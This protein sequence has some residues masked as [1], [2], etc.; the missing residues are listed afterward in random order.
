MNK[1]NISTVY[2]NY[3][4]NNKIYQCC[5]SF[6]IKTVSMW[7]LLLLCERNEIKCVLDKCI[8]ETS[9]Y[10]KYYLGGGGGVAAASPRHPSRLAHLW[11]ELLT[12]IYTLDLL[13]PN[14]SCLCKQQ[15]YIKRCLSTLY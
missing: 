15:Y 3:T 10:R 14:N 13:P 9:F 2:N 11:L 8:N 12:P 7:L 1:M 4:I 5:V 6:H